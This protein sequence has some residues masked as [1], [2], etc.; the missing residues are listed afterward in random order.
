MIEIHEAFSAL[1]RE[2]LA[3]FIE[4][5]FSAVSP[6]DIY[7]HNWHIELIADRLMQC[8]RGEIKRLIITV[9][10]R[11]L[12][13]IC[14][15]VAFPAW[16]LGKDPSLK[17]ICAS[18]S[19]ELALKH[20]RD[21]RAIMESAWY[22]ELF[23]STRLRRCAELDLETTRKG[24]RY[25]TSVG[26]TLT[27]RGGRFIIIDDAIKPQD[28]MSEVKRNTVKQWYSNTLY[29]RLDNKSED[30][31]IL[32]MQRLHVD[33]L[34]AHVLEKEDWVHLNLPAIAK[35]DETFALTNGRIISRSV[36]D[37]LHPER[38]PEAVL[39]DIKASIGTMNF[40]AQ[41]LQQ[42][43]PEEGNL[44]KWSWF[45]SY[46]NDHLVIHPKYRIVQSWDTASSQSELADFSVCT[47]WIIAGKDYYLVDV[48]RK[49]LDYPDLRK[50]AI[51]QAC[52]FRPH[53]ILIE[54]TG[55]GIALLQ[56]LRKNSSAGMSYPIAIIP[57]G[58]KVM[59][60]SMQS[61]IIEAGHVFIPEK[62][63]WLEELHKEFMAFPRGA[64]DDQVD[65]VSQFL[66]WIDKRSR[67]QLHEVKLLGF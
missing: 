9:P 27:G 46:D 18:Y 19:N 8:Y 38:E 36:G 24:S 14:G 55:S 47:T 3:A 48:F 28:G 58:D 29:T 63:P 1:L 44:V 45:R 56:E 52:R 20:A 5:V 16:L 30:V 42:P 31:I 60:M 59:R 43:V 2:Q 51:D 40:S 15:S 50:A 54:K 32:I 11:S 66:N 35:I 33:D 26:G 39:K 25:A 34:V 61:A 13:S 49:R 4:K 57:E 37:I 62:A 64:H 10:P 7:Q 12:K 67:N 6:S 65:S 21:C 23:P 22:Q 17:I 53:N 41:Y